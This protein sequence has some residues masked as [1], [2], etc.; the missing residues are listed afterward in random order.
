[1]PDSL[2]LQEPATRLRS[3]HEAQA[4]VLAAVPISRRS[5]TTTRAGR[6]PKFR[7]DRG[8]PE[9]RIAARQFECIGMS[10]PQDHPHIID[11]ADRAAILCPYCAT[12]VRFDA[13]WGP[14]EADPPDSLFVAEDRLATIATA[15]P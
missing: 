6:Y 14:F 10:P 15:T 4:P 13:R 12:R 1:M 5:G 11:M 2:S 9:I 7:N 8:V 3:P